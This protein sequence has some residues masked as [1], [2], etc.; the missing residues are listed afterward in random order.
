M[1]NDNL[2]KLTDYLKK[3]KEERVILSLKD[4]ES[5]TGE[6]L[7]VEAKNES[8]W[9]N[10]S[11]T[12]A[13]A[14]FWTEAGYRTIDCIDTLPTENICFSKDKSL[15]SYYLS[16]ESIISFISTVFGILSFLIPNIPTWERYLFVILLL[17]FNLVYRSTALQKKWKRLRYIVLIVCLVVSG[18]LFIY[19]SISNINDSTISMSRLPLNSKPLPIK[20]SGKDNTVELYCSDMLPVLDFQVLNGGDTAVT[21]TSVDVIIDEYEEFSEDDI[22]EHTWVNTDLSEILLGRE[23]DISEDCNIDSYKDNYNYNNI[24][25]DYIDIEGKL[26]HDMA[27]YI[28]VENGTE[29]TRFTIDRYAYLRFSPEIEESGH[30]VIQL[31]IHYTDGNGQDTCKSGKIDFYYLNEQIKDL[32]D[33]SPHSVKYFIRLGGAFYNRCD[34][35][36]ALEYFQEALTIQEESLGVDNPSTAATYCCIAITY[37]TQGNNSKALEFFKKALL[38]REKV[39]GTD[40]PSTARTYCNIAVVYEAQDKYEESLNYYK[41]AIAIQEKMPGE[42]QRDVAWSYCGI[43]DVYEAQHNYKKA[44]EYYKKALSIQEK[45]LGKDHTDTARTFDH[46]A[47]LYTKQYDYEKAEEYYEKARVIR[48][49]EL[50]LDHPF[51]A[52]TYNKIAVMYSKQ[53]KYEK[54]QRYYEKA[55]SI[56]EKVLGVN[57]PETAGTYYN[58]ALMYFEKGDSEKSQDYYKKALTV[59]EK[60]L[61]EEHPDTAKT[62]YGIAKT[63]EVQE[64]YKKAKEYFNKALTIQEKILGEDHTDTASTYTEVGVVYA[65]QGDYENALKY[66]NK[67]LVIQEKVLGDNNPDTARTY[68]CFGTF[69]YKSGNYQE[70]KKYYQKAYDGYVNSIGSDYPFVKGLKNIIDKMDA[71]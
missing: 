16:N 2:Q 6:K 26:Y 22:L 65:E 4:I 62:Y 37:G 29:D 59:R 20:V 51:T 46:L 36:K 30:Y 21:A 17:V 18:L 71:E 25:L 33:E 1:N 47:S 69:Y 45:I 38:I 61:G 68:Y 57:N 9:W 42:K 11:N 13:N 50:G 35:A 56:Q 52:L 55:L 63:Y 23:N 66:F 19:S 12:N 44:L 60:I 7:P 43:A 27:K 5:I 64:N 40:H 8:N 67:A 15:I 53:R 39:L 54:A 48:E 10:N 14:H 32:F 49:K 34:Y 31:L 24:K 28:D 3:T 58:Y 70:S 41:K